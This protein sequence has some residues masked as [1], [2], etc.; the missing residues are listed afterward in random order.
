MADTVASPLL[1]LLSDRLYTLAG[2]PNSEILRKLR[3]TLAR[4]QTLVQEAEMHSEDNEALKCWITE[5][6]NA[7]YE[8]DDL[9][10]EY[11][12][13][14][15]RHK[16]RGTFLL[17][18]F[19]KHLIFGIR[20]GGKLEKIEK[21]LDSLLKRSAEFKRIIDACTP[22]GPVEESH[23]AHAQGVH[24]VSSSFM[25]DSDVV[26]REFDKEN[27]LSVLF[28]PSYENQLTVIPIVGMGGVG[29]TTLAQLIYNDF[30]ASDHFDRKMWVSVGE[31]FDLIK[32][33][34]AI[35]EQI[36]HEAKNLSN[37]EVLQ[38]TLRHSI[39]GKRILLV[40]DDV[41]NEDSLKWSMMSRGFLGAAHLESAVVI[42]TRNTMVARLSGTVLPYYLG[43]LD[44]EDSWSLFR[45]FAF[46]SIHNRENIELEEIGRR[47][48]QRCGG[49]PL[50]IKSL[51]GLMGSKEKA[52][53]WLFFME[54]NRGN[55]PELENHFF[56]VLRLSYNHLPS[57]LKQCFAYCSIFPKNHKIYREKLIQLWIAE[58]FVRSGKGSRR[59]EDAANGY[60]MELIERSF[61]VQITRDEFGEIRDCR[62]HDLVHDLAQS[63]ASVG[64]SILETGNSQVVSKELRHSSLVGKSKTSTVL[65]SLNEATNLRTLLLLS[66]K[67]DSNP[68]LL[69]NLV[70]LRV[71]DLSESGIR[72]LSKAIGNLK[73]LRYLNLSHTHIKTL[74][75]SISN[76]RNLQTLELVECYDFQELPRAICELTNLRNLD[77]QSC[78]LLIHIPRGIG[79][80]EFLQRLPV[81]LVNN[82]DG[83]AGLCELRSLELRER[84]EIKNLKFVKC[85][86][87][88]SEA[89]LHEKAGIISLALSWGE[90]T[91]SVT[92]VLDD[93]LE[94][95]RP[96]PH[97]KVLEIT[98]YKGLTSPSWLRNQYLPNLVK[99]S[100]AN[101][102]CRKLPPLGDLP[103]LNDLS[104]RV[105][106]SK[107]SL[108]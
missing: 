42:T 95:L 10:D 41:W 50:A 82:M 51:A 11:D 8:A 100:L 24:R 32:I 86:E 5:I 22:K 20:L 99:L 67:L 6:K 101:C 43:P 106:N 35:I 53:E 33:A 64:C 28:K 98:G 75:E 84:L 63:V 26:G 3:L 45:K 92:S 19:I 23:S 30:R 38:E 18:F 90:D 1:Q 94:K 40:L 13:W 57:H 56:S 102:S 77:F 36:N 79:K 29:K 80:L 14:T 96:T 104:I 25:I 15:K 89:K 21:N 7:A 52:R 71:L 69:Q 65:E 48:V 88:A 76:L 2:L 74:P 73:H 107:P 16:A 81:F 44:E 31:D 108:N 70:C 62:M 60:F 9:F 37:L 66:C 49:L 97:L 39:S 46:K 27:I 68:Q 87:D 12:L 17:S 83:S 47:I 78:P 34:K 55:L 105:L 58:G 103:Y 93:I 91:D 61:F 4:V 85:A 54:E 72:K 59:P